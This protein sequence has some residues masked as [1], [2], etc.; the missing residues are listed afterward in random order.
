MARG[1]RRFVYA[2][3]GKARIPARF[4]IDL[5][6]LGKDASVARGED[7]R[8]ANWHGYAAEVL[9][10]ADGV[11]VAAVD[12]M[13]ESESIERSRG[14]MPLEAASGNHVILDLGGGRYAIYEHLK[15]DSIRVRAGERVR[16]GQVLALLGNSG[17]SSS[18]PHL[19]FHVAD[20]PSTLAAEGMP[21]VFETFDVIGQFEK[22]G[23]FATGRGRAPVGRERGGTRIREYP[24]A[25]A[26][27][28][29]E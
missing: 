11:I 4:A 6:R 10:V 9:A 8:I 12:D 16:A 20:A 27:V 17:S 26:V 3:E 25:N 24:D 15:H 29:F 23:D 21:F 13:P 1:H 18:G 2:V 14:P 7:S 5:V 19:H 22:I 28:V